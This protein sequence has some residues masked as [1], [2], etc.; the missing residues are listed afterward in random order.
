MAG[1]T[2][3]NDFFEI[4]KIFRAYDLC[5]SSSRFI[6]YL[7]NSIYIMLVSLFKKT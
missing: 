4:D 5:L 3:L 2:F 7:Q 1:E 6:I